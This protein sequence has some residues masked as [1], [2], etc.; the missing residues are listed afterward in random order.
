MPVARIMQTSIAHWRRFIGGLPLEDPVSETIVASWRRCEWAGVEPAPGEIAFCRVP[1]TELLFRQ[2]AHQR[3]IEAATRVAPGFIGRLPE[4]SLVAYV[5]DPDGVILCSWGSDAVREAFGLLPGFDW[6]E[7][8]MGTNGAG[9]CLATRRPVA[10]V[11][12]EHYVKEFHNCTCTAAPIF[13]RSGE[14]LG[15]LDVS[16]TVQEAQTGRLA[17]V[18]RAAREIEALLVD[19]DR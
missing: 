9:T 15:A 5:T 4:A 18:V 7:K 6:S 14:L 13:R 3:L 11:G 2:S 8:T 12:P 16:S 19:P 17:L 10:V 1:H